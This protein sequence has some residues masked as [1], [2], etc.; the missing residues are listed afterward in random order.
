MCLYLYRLLLQCSLM[1]FFLPDSQRNHFNPRSV[2]FRTDTMLKLYVTPLQCW[3]MIGTSRRSHYWLGMPEARHNLWYAGKKKHCGH[4][5]YIVCIHWVV[6]RHVYEAA[7]NIHPNL[8]NLYR[9]P[10][11]LHCCFKIGSCSAET[12]AGCQ[13]LAARHHRHAAVFLYWVLDTQYCTVL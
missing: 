13:R 6:D 2:L 7:K 4:C 1:Y 5:L 10:N 8:H 9:L 3:F 11:M 12:L